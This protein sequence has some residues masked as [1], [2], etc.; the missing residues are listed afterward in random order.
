MVVSS[1]Y[2]VVSY[3]MQCCRQ[4]LIVLSFSDISL[5]SV[6]GNAIRQENLVAETPESRVNELFIP[7]SSTIVVRLLFLLL[8]AYTF[9]ID[10][11]KQYLY[12]LPSKLDSDDT[13]PAGTGQ[14][15]S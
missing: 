3:G 6:H 1:A 2:E 13:D 7:M 14:L 10:I 15:Q 4:L 5:L 11:A 12:M 9:S 8:N